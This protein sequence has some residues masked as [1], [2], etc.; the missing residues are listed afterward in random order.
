MITNAKLRKLC[1]LVPH[2]ASGKRQVAA[3]WLKTRPIQVF[4]SFSFWEIAKQ[5]RY[6]FLGANTKR[7]LTRLSQQQHEEEEAAAEDETT[8]QMGMGMEMA[9]ATSIAMAMAMS[10]RLLAWPILDSFWLVMSCQWLYRRLCI[11]SHRMD[12]LADIKSDS[13]WAMATNRFNVNAPW[14]GHIVVQVRIGCI[15]AAAGARH[16]DG[17]LFVQHF[18]W[19]RKLRRINQ[20]QLSFMIQLVEIL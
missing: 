20:L 15:R 10:I 18:V 1:Q 13:L 9:M 6:N 11:A 19:D 7:R 5:I 2:V 14:D 4:S 17:A 12:R 3:A 8:I 16:R